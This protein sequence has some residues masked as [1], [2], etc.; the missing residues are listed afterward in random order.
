MYYTV[1]YIQEALSKI[2]EDTEISIKLK[3]E[4]INVIPYAKDILASP[5]TTICPEK[6]G[7]C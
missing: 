1:L 2:Q 5:H 3:E 7:S 4:T 6:H